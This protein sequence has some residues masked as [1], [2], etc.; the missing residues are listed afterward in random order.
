MRLFPYTPRGD[1]VEFVSLVRDTVRQRSHAVV[2]SG[3]GTGKTV[4]ALAGSL[5]ESLEDQRKLVYITRTKSQQR[6]V[7]LELRRISRI[8]GLLGLSMQGRGSSCP[9]AE[10]D[11]ELK[12][13]SAEELSGYCAQQKR[14]AL[15]GDQGCPYYAH[16]LCI[17]IEELAAFCRRELPTAEEFA[18]HCLRQKACPYEAMKLLLPQADVVV[19]PY[20][21]LFLPFIRNRFLEWLNCDIEDLTVV[22]DEAHNLPEYLRGVS[23]MG[24]SR[25]ALEMLAKESDEF[26]DPEVMDGVSVLDLYGIMKDLLT[27]AVDDYL[28]DEDGLLPPGFVNEGLLL[29]LRCSSSSLKNMNHVLIDHGIL[30]RDQKR[31]QGRLPRSYMLSLGHFL[32]FWTSLEE[33]FYVRLVTG[34]E[35]PSF[36]TYCLDASL[37][38]EPLRQCHSSIHMS[39]TLDPIT[40]YRDSLGLARNTVL[41][42]FKSPF[43]SRNLLTL[44]ADDV[45]TKYEEMSRDRGMLPRLEEYVVGICNSTDRNTAV[46]FPSY[47]LMDRFISDGVLSR[48][49]CNVHVEA[50]GMPQAEL[51]E[52]VDRFRCSRGDVLFSVM[53]GRVSEGLDF[54]DEDMEVAVVVGIPYPRPSARQRA[55]MSYY[56]QKFNKGWEYTVKAPT[57]RKMRQA[58]GRLIRSET[59]RGAAVILD[60]RAQSFP[61]LDAAF[62][63]EPISEVARFFQEAKVN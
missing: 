12:S 47:G 55:L 10:Q 41:R 22:V 2:E 34:G 53:G 38:A 21:Y 14:L 56:D 49:N 57:V 8:Q 17:D 33:R 52:A 24:Y 32:Q 58:I 16:T 1:Q 42:Y 23:S 9:M 63:P 37:A 40:E 18:D 26:Q 11:P 48:L 30:A 5:E 35:N 43:P 50:K 7:M 20:N 13:G 54:P 15:K 62:S 51:M 6:Q 29:N 45:S 31:E 4:C 28:G 44:Y 39:G 46:F 3:T 60:R 25:Y 61:Q 36:E 27:E 59:D 19:A